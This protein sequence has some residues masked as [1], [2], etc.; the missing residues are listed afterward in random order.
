MLLEGRELK[1]PEATQLSAELVGTC[2]CPAGPPPGWAPSQL[3]LG[4]W[5]P[6][7][8]GWELLDRG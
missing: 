5:V 7:C 4:A 6:G 3:G 2:T 1:G 8:L